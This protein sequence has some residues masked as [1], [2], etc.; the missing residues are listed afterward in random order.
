MM[1]SISR[2]LQAVFKGP[3]VL[4]NLS[5][6][7]TPGNA[8]TSLLGGPLAEEPKTMVEYVPQIICGKEVVPITP[9]ALSHDLYTTVDRRKL[10]VPRQESRLIPDR[11]YFSPR[12]MADPTLKS[13][14]TQ[15]MKYVHSTLVK[16]GSNLTRE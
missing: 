9:S 3:N 12:T 1:F 8:V 16:Y 10:Y 14:T 7:A 15:F 5:A 4:I 13:Y 11:K 2:A 6:T